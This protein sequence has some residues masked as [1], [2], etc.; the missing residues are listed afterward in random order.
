[1][2]IKAM[3]ANMAMLEPI[4]VYQIGQVYFVLDGHHRVSVARELGSTYIEADVTEVYTRVPLS[5]DVQ[6]DDLIVKAE[7]A[8]FLEHT[9]LDEIRPGSDLSMTLLGQYGVLEAQ[10]ETHRQS[11]SLEAKR[12]IPAEEVA[13]SWYDQVYLPVVQVIRAQDLL[14]DFPGRTET[15]LYLWLS[16][17]RATLEQELGYEVEISVAATDLAARFS[18]TLPRLIARTEEKLL[19]VITPDALEAG[20]SPGQWRRGRLM[21]HQGE[22]LFADILVPVN[23]QA[24]GWQVLDQAIEVAQ[25]EDGRLHGLYVIKSKAHRDNERVRAVQAEF[26]RRCQAAGL[27]S[28]LA[29]EVGG[30]ARQICQRSQWADLVVTGLTHPP[31]PQPLARLSS[32]FGVLIRRCGRPVLVAPSGADSLSPKGQV[33]RAL[34]AYDGSSKAD[35]ALFVA[36]HLG[37]SRR[38]NLALTVVTV[39]EGERITPETLTRAQNYLTAN[40]VKATVVPENG[41]VAE[42][43]L[44]TATASESDLIIMGSY[45]FS[46]VL[47]IALGSAVDQLLRLSR[48]PVLVCR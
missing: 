2:K 25:R 24:V 15:D 8:G 28:E 32:G 31:A 29:I 33:K 42:A 19:D 43:I 44:K 13:G 3:V 6:P 16:K 36:A 23:G 1:M 40:G 5:P 4:K 27:S 9:R 7:Y 34:L 41:P 38:W 47:E 26:K 37:R 17:H 14:S 12:E 21:A 45:G 30:I 10:I 48:L 35:E 46:P 18:P 39:M 20:P 22:R 11:M